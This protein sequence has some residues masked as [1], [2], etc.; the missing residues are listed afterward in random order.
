MLEL[1]LAL[2]KAYGIGL[3]LRFLPSLESLSSNEAEVF[4]NR[5][6]EE[7]ILSPRF[8]EYPPAY[9]SRL[10]FWKYIVQ[11]IEKIGEVSESFAVSLGSPNYTE[12]EVD[13]RIYNECIQLLSNKLVSIDRNFVYRIH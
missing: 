8:Q 4:Q 3:P 13:E 10:A 7:I 5:L 11:E 12:Q 9:E 1:I 6:A 2:K